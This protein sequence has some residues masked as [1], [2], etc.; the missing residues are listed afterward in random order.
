MN[1]VSSFQSPNQQPTKSVI[2]KQMRQN[3]CFNIRFR[4][5]FICQGAS[6]RR[7]RSDLIGLRVKLPPISTLTLLN[8]ECQAGKL[9]IPT[10]KVF[11]YDLAKK[12][13]LVYQLRDERSNHLNTRRLNMYTKISD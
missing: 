5:S 1:M 11:W 10:F 2:I 9:W 8:A 13:T 6:T 12:S 7:Q 3:N 4:H